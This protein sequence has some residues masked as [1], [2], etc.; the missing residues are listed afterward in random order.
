MS[1]AA[2]IAITTGGGDGD[3]G[4]Q[5]QGGGG[6]TNHS[7]SHF[8]ISQLPS[9]TQGMSADEEAMKR[10][11]TCRFMEEAGRVLKLPRVA[12]STG[13]VFFHRFYAKHAFQEHDRFEVAVAALVLAA[14]TEEAPKKVNT[15]IQECYKLK[16][17]AMQAGRLSAQQHKRN[18]TTPT[19]TSDTSGTS[20]GGVSS[21]VS[22][23][24]AGGEVD[25]SSSSA[26]TTTTTPSSSYLDTKGEDFLKLKERI[27][28]LERIILHTIG[29]ELSIDH[30]YK[31][32]VDMIKKLISTRQL[33]Y[34]KTSKKS[35]TTTGSGGGG[36]KKTSE[37]MSQMM[38][39]LVQYSMSTA[40]DSYQTSLCLQFGPQEIATACVYLACMFSDVEPVT[41]TNDW[42]HTLV[43]ARSSTSSSTTTTNDP[44][45]DIDVE[46]LVSLCVQ[47]IDLIAEK[48][49]SDTESVRKIRKALGLLKSHNSSSTGTTTG[50]GQQP[51]GPSTTTTTAATGGSGG[52]S[53]RPPHPPSGGSDGGLAEPLSSQNKRPRV[54]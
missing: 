9:I 48:K 35:S 51:V 31:F 29:F 38:N 15:V 45:K 19:T 42:K 23:K 32:F 12:I 52:K 11:K 18:T 13:M 37:I 30:P 46:A 34:T 10:R 7:H 47:I 6:Y 25:A 36:T 3:G 2:M 26:T 5:Q 4:T 1:A 16:A 49:A 17:R 27:L 54:G 21:S 40:N 22:P 41:G 33:Q 43:A 50:Q 39:E 14:K 20:G 53:P 44:D 28:L 8:D 24:V